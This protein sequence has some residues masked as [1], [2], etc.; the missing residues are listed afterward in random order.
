MKTHHTI[1][2]DWVTDFR[3]ILFC[4]A[5][6]IL[7]ILYNVKEPKA[8]VIAVIVQGVGNIDGF[9]DYLRMKELDNFL[10]AMVALLIFFSAM[11]SIVGIFTLGDA[12]SYFDLK[13]NGHAGIYILL[14]V[15]GVAFPIVLLLT[16]GILNI[17]KERTVITGQIDG[18]DE[19]EL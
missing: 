11:A 12:R 14:E 13:V 9:W 18:G 6:L 8:L 3:K 19:H 15:C 17:M 4:I 2:D 7:G 10:K 1:F 16:D 5:I